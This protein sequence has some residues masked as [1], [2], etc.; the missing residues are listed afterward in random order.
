M[1][2]T[3]CVLSV[4]DHAGWAY[5]VGVAAAGH[6]PAVVERRTVT[7][8][9]AGL[10]TLPYHHESLRLQV[11]AADALIARVRRSIAE[12]AA[13]ALREVVTN[14]AP[15]YPVVALAIREP[16]F[17]ELPDTV[18][19]VRPSYRL[20]CAADGMMYQLAL[21]RAARDLGLEVDQCRRGDETARAAARLE[22]HPEDIASFVSGAGRPS[23]PPWTQEH[24]R[25]FAAGIAA[26]AARA[27]R[28]IG[29]VRDWR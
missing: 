6:R 8:I 23:G 18:A 1:T 25:A 12:C 5:V 3:P 19:K 15:A 27:P 26:L 24:R 22:V 2:R 20:Q 9:E 16:P 14:L 13:Q 28:L 7:L 17:P 11:D 29:R 4:A 10:P 21:C